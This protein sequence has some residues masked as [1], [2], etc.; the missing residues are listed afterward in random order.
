MSKEKQKKYLEMFKDAKTY[1]E[2]ADLVK[3]EFLDRFSKEELFELMWAYRSS[4]KFFIG[5]WIYPN[6]PQMGYKLLRHAEEGA[7]LA[8]HARAKDKKELS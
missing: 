2:Q 6:N 3:K 1:D 5:H 4:V 8:A 7:V